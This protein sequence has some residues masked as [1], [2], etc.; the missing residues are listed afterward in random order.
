MELRVLV[1][2]GGDHRLRDGEVEVLIRVK[3]FNRESPSIQRDLVVD[4]SSQSFI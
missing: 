2:D 3:G 4:V 1:H